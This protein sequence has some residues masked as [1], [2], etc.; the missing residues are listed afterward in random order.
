[1][2]KGWIKGESSNLY[3]GLKDKDTENRDYQPFTFAQ[4]NIT[5]ICYVHTP[6]RWSN[7]SDKIRCQA[8]HIGDN[9]THALHVCTKIKFVYNTQFFKIYFM[10]SEEKLKT[11][12]KAGLFFC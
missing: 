6:I 12:Q 2:Q 4:Q 8:T 5:K 1:M 11:S 7:L 10:L 3:I 9:K